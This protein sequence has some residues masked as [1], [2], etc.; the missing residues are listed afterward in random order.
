MHCPLHEVLPLPSMGPAWNTGG[1]APTALYRRPLLSL[2]VRQPIER[3]VFPFQ[4]SR[5]VVASTWLLAS[6][7]SFSH[8][9]RPKDYGRDLYSLMP[10]ASQ[11]SNTT[12]LG[13]RRT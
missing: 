4:R 13:S 9:R 3:R 2:S 12:A 11:S 6:S 10:D 1:V 5:A 8:A 7:A